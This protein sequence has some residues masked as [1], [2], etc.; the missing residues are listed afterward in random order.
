MKVWTGMTLCLAF[1]L[2]GCG[3]RSEG[4]HS[5]G[6]INARWGA[7]GDE[8]VFVIFT[9]L[10]EASFEDQVKPH[11]TWHGAY[12]I[13]SGAKLN[14]AADSITMEIGDQKYLLRKGRIFIIT[15]K[16]GAPAVDQLALNINP[17]SYRDISAKLEHLV[18][19][20]Q[21]KSHFPEVT[22]WPDQ[23]N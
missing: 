21:V 11:A 20:D 10:K 1:A 22:W 15:E 9:D 23:K 13:S 14:V 4:V 16:D 12:Q 3:R 19:T 5:W 7:R 8:I 2:C 18:C 17:G 6:D